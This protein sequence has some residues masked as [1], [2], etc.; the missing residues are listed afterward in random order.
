M[1]LLSS[2]VL[3]Q[4]Y[5]KTAYIYIDVFLD[6]PCT[7]RSVQVAS[8]HTYKYIYIHMYIYCYMYGPQLE[9]AAATQ[10]E[11]S[12]VYI[13]V[14]V[15]VYICICMCV[16]TH[17]QI[18]IYTQAASSTAE[19]TIVCVFIHWC[20]FPPSFLFCSSLSN[21]PQLELAAATQAASSTA[22]NTKII[23]E[24]ERKMQAQVGGHKSRQKNRNY[25]FY[26]QW[27]GTLPDSPDTNCRVYQQLEIVVFVIVNLP[28]HGT[29]P[30]MPTL[31][32]R[33]RGKHRHS[34]MTDTTICAELGAH[35]PLSRG[36]T[37]GIRYPSKKDRENG[38]KRKK[39]EASSRSCCDLKWRVN[40]T[41]H[42][43]VAAISRL[44]KIICLFFKRDLEKRM[45]SA[46]VLDT[47]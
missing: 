34:V 28:C 24:A 18:H 17:I 20:L 38:L 32:R 30:D 4:S 43:G 19:N 12:T 8:I 26:V 9:L 5:L 44:L 15:C 39:T 31:F 27:W 42:H 37:L 6:V 41:R 2:G 47:I 45:Y 35:H 25:S 23:T 13:Y 16:Y 7:H 36:I 11:S 3:G 21:R 10:A 22:G 29:V 14:F 1:L 40:W 33:Q 46:T